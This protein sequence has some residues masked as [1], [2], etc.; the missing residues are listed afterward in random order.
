[1]QINGLV[2]G[3][4]RIEKLIN[5]GSFASVF[6]AKEEFTNR[7][8]AI[9]ALSK[10]I[11]P[12][13]RMR[14]LLTELSAMGM[15]WGHQN[16]V[17]LYTVEPGDDEYV[18]YIVMEY[19]DGPS[20]R[21]L[22]AV[23]PP[24]PNSAINIALDIC[25]G[26]IAAHDRNIIH[27]DIKPQNILMTSDRVAKISDFGVACIL[28]ATN[29]YAETVAGTRK[30]MA[31]EQYEGNYDYR[32]DLYSTGLICYEMFV[33][34]FPF[35]GRNHDEIQMMKQCKELQFP[36]ELS[37][38]LR[39]FLQKALHSDPRAR[40]QTAMEM[41]N[42]L[43]RIRKNWYTKAVQKAMDTHSDSIYSNSAI[44]ETQLSE[45]REDLRLS[46]EA[47]EVTELQIRHEKQA[48]KE[49]QT[50]HE[51]DERASEHYNRAGR[52][53]DSDDPQCALQEIQQA[54]RLYLTDIHATKKADGAFRKLS[55]K[56]VPFSL[57]TTA[58]ELIKLIDEFPADEM[59]VLQEWFHNQFPPSES[60]VSSFSSALPLAT[61]ERILL[62]S[63]H[64]QPPIDEAS[65]EFLLM[66]LH[67]QPQYPYEDQAA[68]I[69]RLAEEYAKQGKRR[70]AWSAYKKLGEFYRKRAQELMESK[71]WE[72][73]ADCYARSRLAYIVTHRFGSARRC[74]HNAAIYY[75]KLAEQLEK[76]QRW[77]E[78]GRLYTLSAE[79]Y[80]HAEIP[81]K[82][83]E[84]RLHTTVCYF[85]VAE[86][87]RMAGNLEHA[88]DYCERTLLIAQGMPRPSNA[89]TGARKLIKE[90]EALFTV[91]LQPQPLRRALPR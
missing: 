6:R 8:V 64:P 36:D 31:P 67:D 23:K 38:D 85:N 4:Y 55:E 84:S 16:I 18:A 50:H 9:K 3:K 59:L 91:N 32:I 69:C 46:T 83:D 47:A 71:D 90:I 5:T 25:R 86:N 58:Q 51:L 29:E 48:E 82:A 52:Y 17:S 75:D 35:Q 37:E 21:K 14:Y 7:A 62:G 15:N 74:A 70:K 61:D 53:I 2:L 22:M 40:Y 24:P 79:H 27:R 65:P 63:E 57:P 88:Y 10:S 19:V 81:K 39:K 72:L 87:A 43:D 80:A 45:F 56:I 33:G 41:Y 49:Q 30:Y 11:Y 78:A 1:M 73:I 13:G 68:Q 34:S 42:D 44:L 54:H 20:L 89:A 66:Q 26:L 77:T 76:R 28:E 60:S 12:S